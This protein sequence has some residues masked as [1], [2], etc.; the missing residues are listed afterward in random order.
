MAAKSLAGKVAVVTASTDGI[1]LAIARRLGLDGAKVLISSRKQENV[2]RTVRDLQKEDIVVA[3]AV[4]HVAKEADRNNLVEKAVKEF[5]GVDIFVS[6]AAINPAV[7]PVLETSEEVWDRIFDTNVKSAFLLTKLLVPEMLKRGKGSVIYVSSIGAYASFNSIGTYCIS[8]TALLGLTKTLAGELA[9]TGVRVN[10]IAPGIIKTKFSEYIWKQEGPVSRNAAKMIPMKRFGETS[11]I[12]GAASFLASDASSYM[13]G[14]TLVIAGGMPVRFATNSHRFNTSEAC[15]P[16]QQQHAAE[17][18]S[19]KLAPVGVKSDQSLAQSEHALFSSGWNRRSSSAG[20]SSVRESSTLQEGCVLSVP[21][22]GSVKSSRFGSQLPVSASDQVIT[23]VNRRLPRSFNPTVSLDSNN[24]AK[25]G[26]IFQIRAELFRELAARCVSGTVDHTELALGLDNQLIKEVVHELLSTDQSIS[27]AVPR[28]MEILQERTSGPPP[29]ASTSMAGILHIRNPKQHDHCLIALHALTILRF[30]KT[31]GQEQAATLTLSEMESAERDYENGVDLVVDFRGLAESSLQTNG[32]ALI[33]RIIADAANRREFCRRI[34]FI[35][36]PDEYRLQCA[37]WRNELPRDFR[38][39]IWCLSSENLEHVLPD[40]VAR[41]GSGSWP[42]CGDPTLPPTVALSSLAALRSTLSRSK[43]SFNGSLN[44][45]VET[46][47]RNLLFKQSGNMGPSE[48]EFMIGNINRSSFVVCRFLPKRAVYTVAPSRTFLLPYPKRQS[49]KILTNNTCPIMGDVI[50]LQ[51]YVMNSED[52]YQ[53][54]PNADPS[55]MK[56]LMGELRHEIVLKRGCDLV[57]SQIVLAD[58]D[59]SDLDMSACDISVGEW[60]GGNDSSYDWTKESV[61]GSG[62]PLCAAVEIN[63]KRAVMESTQTTKVPRPQPNMQADA[64]PVATKNVSY[65]SGAQTDEKP[66][67]PL[68]R[69]KSGK[70]QTEQG[71]YYST[72]QQ[73][74][75]EE[76]LSNETQTLRISQGDYESQTEPLPPLQFAEIQTDPEVLPLLKEIRSASGQTMPLPEP[77][78]TAATSSSMQTEPPPQPVEIP[79]RTISSQILPTPVDMVFTQT[80]IEEKPK[81]RAK[82]SA[83]NQTDTILLKQT[84]S[85][86]SQADALPPAPLRQTKFDSW[87]T[88]TALLH[89]DSMQIDESQPKPMM[90]A[91]GQTDSMPMPEP[92]RPKDTVSTFGQT[93]PIPEKPMAFG[94][95]QTDKQKVVLKETHSAIG[96]TELPVNVSGSMQTEPPSLISD[97]MQTDEIPVP[98]KPVKSSFGQTFAL[99]ADHFAEVKHGELMATQ[100]TPTAQ[101][102]VQT[103]TD[104]RIV[105]SEFMPTDQVDPSPTPADART[106]SAEMNQMDRAA[107]IDT[108]IGVFPLQVF[109]ADSFQTE[110]VE[111]LFAMAPTES[112]ETALGTTQTG[113]KEKECPVLLEKE[114]PALVDKE[115]P[116]FHEPAKPATDQRSTQADA[117]KSELRGIQTEITETVAL[118]SPPQPALE[119]GPPAPRLPPP[120]VAPPQPVVKPLKPPVIT[121]TTPTASPVTMPPMGH[122]LRQIAN[123]MPVLRFHPLL[124][125]VALLGFA[126]LV[127]WLELHKTVVEYTWVTDWQYKNLGSASDVY[128]GTSAAQK[129][130]LKAAEKVTAKAATQQ[131]GGLRTAGE[132]TVADEYRRDGRNKRNAG[133]GPPTSFAQQQGAG[134]GSSTVGGFRS[135]REP[136]VKVGQQRTGDSSLLWNGGG[137]RSEV[138]SADQTGARTRDGMENAQSTQ[139]QQGFSSSSWFGGSGGDTGSFFDGP[140]GSGQ[141]ARRGLWTRKDS[142]ETAYQGPTG[143]SERRGVGQESVSQ[144]QRQPRSFWFGGGSSS[145]GEASTSRPS[146]TGRGYSE[147]ATQQQGSSWFSSKSQKASPDEAG[148]GDPRASDG[149]SGRQSVESSPLRSPSGRSDDGTDSP[150]TGSSKYFWQSTPD[151]DRNQ[152]SVSGAGSTRTGRTGSKNALD[153][154]TAPKSATGGGLFSFSGERGS[155]HST[156]TDAEPSYSSEPPPVLP[157]FEESYRGAWS[158]GNPSLQVPR[159]PSESYYREQLNYEEVNRRVERPTYTGQTSFHHDG[160]NQPSF[161]SRYDVY[162][163]QAS[164]SQ[165]A[166]PPPP[167]PREYELAPFNPDFMGALPIISGLELT[168][169]ELGLTKQWLHGFPFRFDPGKEESWRSLRSNPGLPERCQFRPPPPPPPLDVKLHKKKCL[170]QFF[171]IEHYVTCRVAHTYDHTRWGVDDG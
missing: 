95:M 160:K 29:A 105:T 66:R 148:G 151:R 126:F 129:V 34:F 102:L 5:G 118:P 60:D 111:Q 142:R 170:D 159:T 69:T 120:A 137:R 1:G 134:S 91:F 21:D 61:D 76:K 19:R 161:V 72:V 17:R 83:T 130:A 117:P 15:D 154:V 127:H 100:T 8:K 27:L 65:S 121:V 140:T 52:G 106:Y 37:R 32:A 136:E 7:G 40:Y 168:T 104:E 25:D 53:I 110:Q 79:K 108:E 44:G 30:A 31:A 103:Q 9:E 73:T 42:E 152:R 64:V 55:S 85:G 101:A 41:I 74:E 153:D 2:E 133:G 54:P 143:S 119:V 23:P 80:D 39:R 56:S 167:P 10:G 51:V 131:G 124:W 132:Q 171:S 97:F 89:A 147:P 46:S 157:G 45:I 156:H 92:P 94:S 112:P 162:G 96:Q 47:S 70:M 36:F 166:S 138:R 87:Q 169:P 114:C 35:D 155:A 24:N 113:F 88:D 141:G 14:E 49:V 67:P 50:R 3:G 48:A 116:V 62:D 26:L 123:F 12:A 28:L 86:I 146:E 18:I 22:K 93:D 13:T 57:V 144:Q 11:E 107:V 81:P 98:L 128:E 16:K 149:T 82:K 90:S 33:R 135:V 20:N 38:K 122:Q 71:D 78:R 115:C 6:N 58:G 139:Q 43:S 125:L 163:T 84:L 145:G 99:L 4:C 77:E 165:P 59:H 75:E 150:S 158:L 68:K 109:T 164:G 63:P